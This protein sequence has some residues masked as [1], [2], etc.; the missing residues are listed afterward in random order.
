MVPST[1]GAGKTEDPCEKE[2]NQTL[3]L[4]H[5]HKNQLQVDWNLRPETVQLPERKTG[6]KLDATGLDND[7]LDMT[8]KAEP[9][10]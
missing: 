10:K 1:N 3:I 5:A 4:H 6:G 7:F 2:W 8:P 9:Q